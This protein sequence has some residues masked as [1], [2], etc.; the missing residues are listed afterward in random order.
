M[1]T[2][3][4]Y[5]LE[6][7]GL[8]SC[9]DQVL[10]FAAIRTNLN[11]SEIENISI[12][13]QLRSDIIP[14]PEAMITHRIP[15]SEL[16]SGSC[17]YEAICRIHELFNK[18]G[19][20]SIGFNNFGFDDEFLRFSFYRNLLNPYSHQYANECGRMDILPIIVIYKL[21]KPEVLIWP[22]INQK[23][24]FKLEYIASANA[25]DCGRAHDA[26]ADVRATIAIAK[27]LHHE[28]KMWDYI[29]SYFEKKIDKERIDNLPFVMHSDFGHHKIGLLI[30]LR[31]GHERNYVLPVLCIG[32]SKPYSNQS[33]W[34]QLDTMELENCKQDT[35]PECSRVIR[36][37]Y[38]EP[39]I[40]LAPHERFWKILN[41]ERRKQVEKNITWCKEHLDIFH[42]IIMY[43]QAFEYPWIPNV[44]V[45][46][47]LYQDGF[48]TDQES[49]FFARFHSYPLEKKCFMLKECPSQRSNLLAERILIR[50]YKDKLTNDLHLSAQEYLKQI[51]A[52]NDNY[53]C[54]DYTGQ[55]RKTPPK[56]LTEIETLINSKT[57]DDQQI[58]L[59]HE[60]RL[61]VNQNLKSL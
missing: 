53:I 26:I 9:F 32:H 18:P 4:F 50:N 17:E 6:T 36:K 5:D 55:K 13:V 48:F 21:F 38:G 15:I 27:V 34:L 24:S 30:D 14:T 28:N 11:L 47:S 59:L 23:P 42:K 8:N 60:L 46:A 37:R 29:I 61:F 22:V 20:I 35:I 49:R 58:Q 25:I 2:Y 7:T 44:D 57:L 3:L 45:D 19:T 1:R 43:Y 41:P 12:R 31:S 40:I 51:Y 39:A 33:L 54:V 16:L 10:Q 56:V 52:A